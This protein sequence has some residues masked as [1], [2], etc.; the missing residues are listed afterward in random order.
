MASAETTETAGVTH[1]QLM[2][3]MNEWAADNLTPAQI[4]EFVCECED[5]GCLE[6]VPLP[7]GDYARVRSAP[8]RFVTSKAHGDVGDDSVR[9][10][11]MQSTPLANEPGR[12]SPKRSSSSQ[13]RS[14]RRQPPTTAG[15]GDDS[16]DGLAWRPFSARYFPGGGRHDLAG[17]KAY[18][19][20]RTARNAERDASVPRGSARDLETS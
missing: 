4:G 12:A 8:G 10:V 17:I 20:H 5:R 14:S 11:V 16:A 19:R 9:L 13:G 6:T 18:E 3:A 7:L 1:Q 15:P 2:V